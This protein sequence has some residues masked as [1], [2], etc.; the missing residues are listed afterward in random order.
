MPGHGPLGKTG[1]T[2]PN[3]N[4]KTWVRILHRPTQTTITATKETIG[5]AARDRG[6]SLI[7][8]TVLPGDSRLREGQ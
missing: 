2:A 8:C 6:W 1:T 4:P 3:G 5:A 7:Q